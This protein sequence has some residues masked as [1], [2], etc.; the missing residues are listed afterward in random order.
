M[1][2]SGLTVG[3]DAQ[4]LKG[5][6]KSQKNACKAYYGDHMGEEN[7][8]LYYQFKL[9]DIEEGPK[10]R[11]QWYNKLKDGAKENEL[12]KIPL[13]LDHKTKFFL[14]PTN[15]NPTDETIKS[16]LN[17]IGKTDDSHTSFVDYLISNVPFK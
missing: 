8:D 12:G 15:C 13:N 14:F 4:N 6:S 16:F 10:I 11:N 17:F 3:L 7:L 9:F 2:P 1:S 5:Q